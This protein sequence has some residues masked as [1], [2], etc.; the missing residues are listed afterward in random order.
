M[1][2]PARARIERGERPDAV[3]TSM[4]RSLFWK[5]KA[6]FAKLLSRW[7]A[8]GLATVAERTGRLESALIFG[9]GPDRETLGEELIAIARAARSR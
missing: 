3:M 1:L 9:A 5:D 8:A 2:A 4:G 6:L 7:D